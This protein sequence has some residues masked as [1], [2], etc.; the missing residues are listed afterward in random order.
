[1][2]LAVQNINNDRQ[3]AVSYGSIISNETRAGARLLVASGSKGQPLSEPWVAV[4]TT[5]FIYFL[6]LGR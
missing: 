4:Q 5:L 1:M 2:L 6:K 3:S